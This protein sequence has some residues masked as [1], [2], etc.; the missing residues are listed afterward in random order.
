M[1]VSA[2]EVRPIM[3]VMR[4]SM[5]QLEQAHLL[6][7]VRLLWS[8]DRPGAR[9]EGMGIQ[10]CTATETKEG[11]EPKVGKSSPL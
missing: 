6:R 2:K 3:L 4:T 1:I 8:Q 9:A 7:A 5:Y 11:K 10:V